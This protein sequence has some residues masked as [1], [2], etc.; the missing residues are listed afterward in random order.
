[1]VKKVKTPLFINEITTS[2]S[3]FAFDALADLGAFISLLVQECRHQIII[4]I[5]AFL[6]RRQSR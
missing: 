3:K 1:M 2:L 5:E 4:A 6:R